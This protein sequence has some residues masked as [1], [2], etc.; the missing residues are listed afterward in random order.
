MTDPPAPLRALL[1][2][3]LAL[4]AN[5]LDNLPLQVRFW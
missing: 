4:I 3:R 5:I 1:R 2:L